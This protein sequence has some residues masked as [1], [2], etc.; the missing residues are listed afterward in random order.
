M[1]MQETS[2]AHGDPRSGWKKVGITG[3]GLLLHLGMG[4]L[5]LVSEILMPPTAV[6]WLGVA[7]AI[8]LLIALTRIDRPSIVIAVPL[9]TFVLWLGTVLVGDAVLSWTA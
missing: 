4:I 6:A 9:G 5:V 1:A 2:R 7:W 8:G 3:I